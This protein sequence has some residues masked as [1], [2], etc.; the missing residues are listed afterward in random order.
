MA[1]GT[2]ELFDVF[3]KAFPEAEAREAA[4]AVRNYVREEKSADSVK[5]VEEHVEKTMARE[6]K[7]L[8][9]KDD[10]R[11]ELGLAKDDLRR[12]LGLAK[13]D[14]Q[15]QMQ[16][17]FRWMVTGFITILLGII[18]LMGTMVWGFI[19]LKM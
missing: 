3:R 17:L 5:I 13:D 14:L 4:Q 1:T 12:E 18:A 9:T 7:H 19:S 16:S 6:L 15:G 2:L 10:L 8:A 11:R